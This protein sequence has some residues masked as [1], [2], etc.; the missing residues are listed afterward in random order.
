MNV[1]D[2]ANSIA[3]S[4]IEIINNDEWGRNSAIAFKD[5]SKEFGWDNSVV[6]LNRM[7]MSL[8]NKRR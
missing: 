2:T 5:A 3:D 7:M 8:I 4:V 6:E 1:E